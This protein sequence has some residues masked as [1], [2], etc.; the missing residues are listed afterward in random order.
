MKKQLLFPFSIAVAFGLLSSISACNTEKPKQQTISQIESS[1]RTVQLDKCGLQYEAP[2]E[3]IPYEQTNIIPITN[4]TTE[5]DI[6]AQI[7]YNYVTNEGMEQL[8]TFD[9]DTAVEELLY[10]FG[11]ILV[12]KQNKLESESIQQEFSL[13]HNKQQIASQK[14]YVYY[15]L[16][17]Y[18]GDISSLQEQDLKAYQTLSGSMETLKQTVSVYPF[19]ETIVAEAIDQIRR[20]I[21]FI[22]TTLEGETIDSSL[23]ANADLTV[24]NFWAS[25]CYPN[26]N[27]TATLQQLKTELE[28]KYDNVQFVQVVIDTPQPEAEKIAKQAK[29]EANADFISI[30]PDETLGNWIL[31]NLE[32]LPTTILVNSQAQMVGEKIQGIQSLENYITIIE[33]ALSKQE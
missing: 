26:I 4:T 18:Q 17:E 24:V 28:Q 5:G 14:D 31:Q 29:Q 7:Q 1:D 25:Y 12:F 27:E 10:P 22:S 13:Y 11:E 33:N 3:W 23:F 32:G 15:M 2:D 6:Y 30:M 20:T 19:D 9:N 16:T 8:A 21:S